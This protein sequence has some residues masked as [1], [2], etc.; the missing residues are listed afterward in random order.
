MVNLNTLQKIGL[1]ALIAVSMPIMALYVI[2][3][4][5]AIATGD[6]NIKFRDISVVAFTNSSGY[7][8]TGYDV[9]RT[10]TATLDFWLEVGL[11]VYDDTLHNDTHDLR[12]YVNDNYKVNEANL[13]DPNQQVVIPIINVVAKYNDKV[14]G[15]GGSHRQYILNKDHP[16]E[17]VHLYLTE[18]RM[19]DGGLMYLFNSLSSGGVL[20]QILFGA[21]GASSG[22]EEVG[23]DALLADLKL[24][25]IAYI[26]GAPLELPLDLSAFGLSPFPVITPSQVSGLPQWMTDANNT[27][28]YY[29][30]SRQLDDFGRLMDQLG[31]ADTSD[32]FL[33]LQNIMSLVGVGSDPMEILNALGFMFNQ[34][35][36]P[37]PILYNV[38]TIEKYW[39]NGNNAS[40][41]LVY[42]QREME[43][44]FLNE[45]SA[46]KAVHDLGNTL[47]I[48]LVNASIQNR[49]FVN[50]YLSSWAANNSKTANMSTAILLN[51]TSWFTRL[52]VLAKDK[53]PFSGY[54]FDFIY[55]DDVNLTHV[56]YNDARGESISVG[57]VH[58]LG[59][60]FGV[61]NSLGY[62]LS[63]FFQGLDTDV[64]SLISALLL[65]GIDENDVRLFNETY[66]MEAKELNTAGGWSSVSPEISGILGM[67]LILVSVIIS[68]VLIFLI[69]AITKA[70]VKINRADFLGRENVTRNV[71]EFISKVD[72]LGGKV[73]LRNAESLVIRAFRMEG[74]I[75][76]PGDV[77][78]RSKSYVENQKLLV[79]LQSRASRA[80]VAQKFKDC[81]GAIEKMIQIARKLEDQ[82]L[83]Q[84]YEENLAKV[85]RLLRRKGINVSTKV[86]VDEG[87][88]PGEEVEQLSIYKKELID[89]QN[90]ASKA[91]AE[92]N[93]SEAK[94]SIKQMLAI[95][96][97]IQDPVLI[98]NYEA[99]LRKII[100]MEKGG[101]V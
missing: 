58:S 34:L 8:A 16:V 43:P 69:F 42:S 63:D 7:P 39:I 87:A 78:K 12:Y 3:P 90:R 96:K 56:F 94:E 9:N 13:K 60:L 44:R 99:N 47:N 25:I 52:Y 21:L 1:V 65:H 14:I 100:A 66:S 46:F 84:N 5:L 67:N 74:K 23:F 24:D 22:G 18:S 70:R 31:F 4:R 101:S 75:D 80:Y 28:I 53:L 82:T 50:S 2:M 26:G 41:D 11:P 57:V 81:I 97:K 73:S 72:Q 76:K 51:Q 37:T 62:G 45:L 27:I 98:R 93:F 15:A 89:L 6:L 33:L 17:Y 79:T 36:P 49:A 10:D 92:K 30:N 38:T 40:H 64:P 88:K 59:D 35:F 68:F 32:P 77:E 48:T 29:N 83:V 91:F 95:A 20:D 85:V 19:P 54:P 61:I 71:K 86:R 55:L